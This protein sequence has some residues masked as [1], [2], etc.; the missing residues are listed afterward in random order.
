MDDRMSAILTPIFVF[1]GIYFFGVFMIIWTIL[2]RVTD[3]RDQ[4]Y[5]IEKLERQIGRLEMKIGDLHEKYIPRVNEFSD[6][7]P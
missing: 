1:G 7:Q 4:K 5:V 3:V 6:E 2:E